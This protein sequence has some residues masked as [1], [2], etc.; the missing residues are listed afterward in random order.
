MGRL[1]LMLILCGCAHPNVSAQSVSASE[2]GVQGQ[3]ESSAGV[4][5]RLGARHLGVSV[6]PAVDGGAPTF[7]LDVDDEADELSANAAGDADAG[8]KDASTDAA[9]AKADDPPSFWSPAKLAVLG[10]LVALVGGLALAWKL[11]PSWMD[12]LWKLLRLA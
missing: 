6:I 7:K 9:G 12:W 3:I 8:V 2:I 5:A 11:K 4:R 1:G 10:G